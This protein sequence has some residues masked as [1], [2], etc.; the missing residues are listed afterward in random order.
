MSHI[1]GE[2]F[3]Y[4]SQSGKMIPSCFSPPTPHFAPSQLFWRA[5]K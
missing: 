3:T 2:D 4:L 5:L 1:V